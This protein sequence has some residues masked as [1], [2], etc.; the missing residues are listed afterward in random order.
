MSPSVA[1]KAMKI[2]QNPNL[3]EAETKD[4]GLSEREAQVLRHLCKGLN[5]NQIA[6]NLIISPNTVRRHIENIYKKLE[7]NNKSEAQQLAYK[8]NLV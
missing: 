5:Y 8:F 1:R 4:F 7:V 2:I 6:S 3:L